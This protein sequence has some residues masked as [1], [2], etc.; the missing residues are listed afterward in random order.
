MIVRSGGVVRSIV[1]VIAVATLVTAGCSGSAGSSAGRSR[2][3]ASPSTSV[4]SP[5]PST[6][7]S[8][9]G[10]TLRYVALGDSDTEGY[11][12]SVGYPELFGRAL[13]R[14]TGHPVEV[15]NL[16]RSG[17]ASGNLLHALTTYREFRRALARADVVTVEIGGTDMDDAILESIPEPC[18]PCLQRALD[19]FEANLHQ[20]LRVIVSHVD[21]DRAL[22]RVATVYDFPAD[23]R[24]E[25]LGTLGERYFNEMNAFA[26]RAAATVGVLCADFA[27]AL[28]G[29]RGSQQPPD[30]LLAGDHLHLNGAGHAVQTRV[31][32]RLGFSPLA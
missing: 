14:A 31:L 23:Y 28:N 25:G 29:P 19:A 22:V 11:L 26:C 2:P 13:E 1:A 5:A 7:P 20:I 30:D 15:D 18:R 16:G 21:P 6:A 3:P 27:R 4:P 9:S 24:S 8:L 12:A 32:I 10:R 17:W